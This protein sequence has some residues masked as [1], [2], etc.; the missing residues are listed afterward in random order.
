MPDKIPEKKKKILKYLHKVGYT[1]QPQPLRIASNG[2]KQQKGVDICCF[3]SN[4]S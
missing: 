2:T 4:L 1:I 3:C